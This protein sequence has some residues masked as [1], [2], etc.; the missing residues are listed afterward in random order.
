MCAHSQL[1]DVDKAIASL[2][3]VLRAGYCSAQLYG[4]G[5][6]NEDY[7][8]L[9]R[10]GDLETA[11]GTRDSSRWWTGTTSSPASCSSSSIPAR[12]SLAEP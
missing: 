11:R 10:D 6:A 12:A 3:A 2:E 7:E 8:R 5:K 1:G 9:M 4:F